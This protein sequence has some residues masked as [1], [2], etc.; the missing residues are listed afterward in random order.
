MDHHPVKAFIRAVL[1]TAG[2]FGGQN[3]DQ[4]FF[5]NSQPKPIPKWVLDEVV[6]SSSSS[7]PPA[8]PD[9][10][11]DRRLLFDLV[12]EH[13]PE[14]TSTRGS[15]TLYTFSK[16]YIAAA[17]RRRGGKRLLDA[18]WRAVQALVEPP[19]PLRH[20][21]DALPT[22]TTTMMSSVDALIGRDMGASPWSGGA[23]R[24]DVDGVGEEVEA[25][26]LGELLDET[27]WDVLLNVGED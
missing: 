24:G 10:V 25:E 21:G 27:L 14:A 26:I 2:M 12:N 20:D 4:M 22:T 19:L 11:V 18:L 1:V 5:S 23:F 8:V 6:S 3:T 13:L 7:S 9:V 16:W 17:P 15:T